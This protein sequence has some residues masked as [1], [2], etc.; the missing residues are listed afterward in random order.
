MKKVLIV[1]V[2]AVLIQGGSA[3]STDRGRIIRNGFVIGA[4]IGGGMLTS[5]TGHSGIHT[6]PR[7]SLLNMKLGYM[8]TPATELWV[9]VPSGGHLENDEMRAFEAIL[10]GGK[11][12]I[13]ERVWAGGAAG[14]AMDMPPFYDIENDNP[15]MHFGFAANIG[16]GYEIIKKRCF[17]MNVRIRYLYGNFDVD[18]SVK[19]CSAID[20]LA[21]IDWYPANGKR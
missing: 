9:S 4:A 14:L 5:A 2:A 10:A 18:G 21:G 3:E 19:Q 7:M 15:V 12:R 17:S 6:C 8:I 11:Y 1:L 20:L 13:T 16:S